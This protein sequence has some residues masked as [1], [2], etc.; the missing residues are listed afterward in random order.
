MNELEKKFETLV[1]T[2][3]KLRSPNGCTW[4]IEQTSQSLIPFFIEEVYEVIEAIDNQD[5]DSVKAVSYT[6]L[7]LPTKRI[8]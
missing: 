1:E 4:D 8:V 3:K 6:H 2:V 7:T 5:W